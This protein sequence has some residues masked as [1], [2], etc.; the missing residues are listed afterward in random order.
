MPVIFFQVDYHKYVTIHLETAHPHYDS[1]GNVL[2]IG[3]SI[4]DKGKTKYVIFK[5]PAKVPGR[6]SWEYKKYG[7]QVTLSEEFRLLFMTQTQSDTLPPTRS[8]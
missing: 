1:A 3:I 7:Q 6:S 8:R 4:V 2:N 5:I